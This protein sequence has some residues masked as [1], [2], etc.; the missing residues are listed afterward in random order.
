MAHIWMGIAGL[1]GFLAVL[2]S[3]LGA[4]ALKL[5][6]DQMGSFDT[7]NRFLMIHAVALLAVSLWDRMA[8]GTAS[9]WIQIA[10]WGFVAGMILF[11]GTLYISS[12][13]GARLGVPLAP[14]GG[15]SFMAAWIALAVSA[16]R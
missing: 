14:L 3:A 16:F 1:A 15:L 7:A 4:H 6:P 11:C 5:T 10:G 9:L 2:L 12:T 8:P 13:L